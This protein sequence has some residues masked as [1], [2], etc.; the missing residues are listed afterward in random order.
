L[1]NYLK[2]C[3]GLEPMSAS[4]GYE[5]CALTSACGGYPAIDFF[6]SANIENKKGLPTE[7]LFKLINIYDGFIYPGFPHSG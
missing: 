6:G 2:N 4:G 5:S 3:D 1:N 7:V